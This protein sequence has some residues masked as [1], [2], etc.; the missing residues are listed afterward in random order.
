MRPSKRPRYGMT[1]MT[2]RRRILTLISLLVTFHTSSAKGGR[3]R[4]RN[5]RC[6]ENSKSFRS[7]AE[8]QVAT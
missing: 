4:E 3:R 6:G 5:H 7:R 1:R 8:N 2:C